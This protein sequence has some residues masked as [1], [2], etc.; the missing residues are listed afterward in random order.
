MTDVGTARARAKAG[1]THHN[2]VV[3]GR[4]AVLATLPGIERLAGG[5]GLP[6][7]ARTAW[8]RAQLD[9]QPEAEPWAVRIRTTDGQLVAAAILLDHRTGARL[10]GGGDDHRGA[11]IAVDEE[12]AAALGRSV[13]AGAD[14][15]GHEAV[16][17]TLQDDHLARAFAEA[18]A[19]N[20]APAPGIPALVLDRGPDLAGY[21]SHGM[22]RTLRKARN[23][24][25][26][27]E[28]KAEVVLT[29]RGEEIA[30]ILPALER[31][32]RDRDQHHG[33]ASLV[34]CSE[35]LTAWRARVRRL[36]EHRCLELATLTV[37]G[38]LAAYVLGLIDGPWYRVLDGRM[39]GAFAR[40]APGRVLEAAVLERALAGGATG[41]DWMTSVAP[42][43]LL[44][45]TTVQPV[46]TL[47]PRR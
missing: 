21:L 18:A 9:S 15:R 7:P 35:E 10:A 38:N 43:T 17:G 6:I 2:E 4:R 28:R 20:V 25:S 46:V 13:A 8:I 45:A 42:E 3:A 29:R 44:A 32:Y 22:L 16:N 26:T 47:T 5:L 41:V 14:R 37:D 31:I 39:D 34:D 40:Y 36:M 30:G 1:S 23:R 24:F 11:V 19:V 12:T 27:D 33:S